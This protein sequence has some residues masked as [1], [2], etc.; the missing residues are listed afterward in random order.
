[1]AY[2]ALLQDITKICLSM[3]RDPKEV[4]VVVAS[5]YF[6]KEQIQHFYDCGVRHFGENRV[7]EA[8]EKIKGLPQDI[9]W[10]FLGHL[11]TN[12]V[13]K[14]VGSFSLIHSVDSLKL[15]EKINQASETKQK[16]LLQIKTSTEESKTGFLESEFIDALPKIEQMEHLEVCGLMTVAQKGELFLAEKSFKALQDL[17][18]KY[19]KPSWELSMGMSQD[20]SVA[21]K[22]GATL[23]RIGRKLID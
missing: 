18:K 21:L 5:K 20:Y 16:I 6:S 22:Y 10:H 1:M 8:L 3:E 12:K 15:T 7:Q 19:G 4:K 17:K 11:Q 14:V 13:N 23:L 9:T 2:K